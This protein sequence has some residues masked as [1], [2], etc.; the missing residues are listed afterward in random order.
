MRQYEAE[1]YYD[2]NGRIVF[3]PSKG[4]PGL[5]LP[6]KAIKDHTGYTLTRRTA[7][8]EGIALGWEYIGGLAEGD[9]PLCRGRTYLKCPF[10][11]QIAYHALIDSRRREQDYEAA[12][13]T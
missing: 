13:L 6:R 4:L 7:R 1:T 10:E 5:G 3:T 11:R 9:H 12:W 2:A 8:Q